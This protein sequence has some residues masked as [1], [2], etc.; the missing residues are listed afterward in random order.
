MI[1]TKLWGHLSKR[2]QKQ[3]LLTLVLMILASLLEVVS[4]GAVI[5]FLGV[6][7]APEEVFQYEILEPMLHIFNITTSEQLIF[8]VTALFIVAALTAGGVRL[9]L[10]YVITRLSYAVGADLSVDIYRRTLYQEYW[11]MCQ[12]IVVR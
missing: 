2:R 10:L 12:E 8:P 6:L 7:I 1:F 9:V 5:P 4:I 11:S 3:F